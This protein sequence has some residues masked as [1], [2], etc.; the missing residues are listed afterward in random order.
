MQIHTYLKLSQVCI[1]LIVGAHFIAPKVVFAKPL[2]PSLENTVNNPPISNLEVKLIRVE[3]KGTSSVAIF[4]DQETLEQEFYSVH[5]IVFGQA[6][7]IEIKSSHA[8]VLYLGNIEMVPL[9]EIKF[10]KASRKKQYFN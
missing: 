4:E 3:M 9:A 5:D 8:L 7:L 6:R 1:C 10:S 2:V